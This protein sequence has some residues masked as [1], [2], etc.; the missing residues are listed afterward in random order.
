V[1]VENRPRAFNF[2]ITREGGWRLV[3]VNLMFLPSLEH[4]R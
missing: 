4:K 3:M 1:K 2:Y